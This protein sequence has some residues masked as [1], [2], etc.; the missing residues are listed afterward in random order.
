MS[1]EIETQLEAKGFPKTGCWDCQT[2]VGR[3]PAIAGKV[4]WGVTMDVE[5]AVWDA[6]DTIASNSRDLRFKPY[7]GK[8]FMNCK[9]HCIVQKTNKK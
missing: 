5:D 2:Y 7:I 4:F 9:M 8:T 1:K 3:F 6:G